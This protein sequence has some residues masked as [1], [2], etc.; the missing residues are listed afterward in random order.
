M[1]L[2][3]NY[4]LRKSVRGEENRVFKPDGETDMRTDGHKYSR[5][6]SLLKQEIRTD[7]SIYRV[8]SLLKTRMTTLIK[9]KLK[10]SD[11]QT[12]IDKYR[13]AANITE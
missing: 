6:A 4:S 2:Y 12:N 10:K 5:V 8:A 1:D 9:T 3:L 11:D 7:I 13:V